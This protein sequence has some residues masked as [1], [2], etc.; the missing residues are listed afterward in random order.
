MSHIVSKSS[1]RFRWLAIIAAVAL[2]AVIWISY[3]TW[4]PAL[5]E[6]FP[7]LKGKAAAKEGG[8]EDEGQAGHDHAG[9]DHP[10]HDELA[11]LELSPQ[12]QANIG[13]KSGKVTIENFWRKITVPGIIVE[14]RGKTKSRIVA[15]LTGIVTKV[16]VIEGEAVRPG[17]PLFNVRLTH[18]DLVQAQVEYLKLVEELDVV[19]L[20]VE[21]LR[22]AA[23][24]GSIPQ[25]TLLDRL[26]EQRKVQASL[27]AHRQSLRLHGL[28]DDQIKE[29]E[30]TR[31]LQ[32]EHVVHAPAESRKQTQSF[33][34]EDLKVDVGRFVNTGDPLLTLSDYSEL[35][36]EGDA[37]EQDGLL[38]ADAIKNGWKVTARVENH[39][40]TGTTISGLSILYLSDQVDPTTR[41]LHFYILLKNEPQRDEVKDGHRFVNWRYKPGQRTQL[42]VPVEEWKDRIVLP[43]DAVVV[44]GAESYVFQQNGKHFDRRAVHVEYR[45]LDSVVIAQDGTLFKGDAVAMSGAQ[46]MLTAL[47]NKAGG[48]ID[49]HA[50]HHH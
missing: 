20:E 22:P 33:V 47:K 45:D 15:P 5:R 2:T 28:Q 18:E 41:T 25:K 17:Q 44:D 13:L 16:Y 23:D 21:R 39:T 4:M 1:P 38:V 10:G 19:N 42:R 46:Q 9:H 26:Y 43:A 36:I 48:G 7:A 11:S 34:V 31:E 8:N 37:F 14:R 29:I 30:K 27:K 50:G 49:P 35:Y 40:P 12:A 24:K 32:S 3:G 6:Q